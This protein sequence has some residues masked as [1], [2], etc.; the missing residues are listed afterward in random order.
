VPE[1]SP[2]FLKDKDFDESPLNVMAQVEFI[3]GL[4][5]PD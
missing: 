2:V 4:G 3:N 1:A 5:D